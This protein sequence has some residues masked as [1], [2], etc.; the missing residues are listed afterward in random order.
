MPH[1]R[2]R[3]NFPGVCKYQND[4]MLKQHDGQLNTALQGELAA[5]HEAVTCLRP[6]DGEREPVV[7]DSRTFLYL[8]MIPS[9]WKSGRTTTLKT[10]YG[11]WGLQHMRSRCSISHQHSI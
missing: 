8:I 2:D 11:T 9:S 7:K 10:M 1:I 3:R 4:L 6:L 5:L